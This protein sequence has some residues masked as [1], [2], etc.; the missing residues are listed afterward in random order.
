MKSMVK[1]IELLRIEGILSKWKATTFAGANRTLRDWS[2]TSPTSGYDKVSVKVTWENGVDLSF[3]LDLKHPSTGEEP[4]VEAEIA[5]AIGFGLGRITNPNWTPRQHETVLQRYRDQGVAQLLEQIDATCVIGDFPEAE[6]APSASQNLPYLVRVPSRESKTP[7]DECGLLFMCPETADQATVLE[8]I[9]NAI[10][11][12]DDDNGERSDEVITHLESHGFRFIGN[13]GTV[14]KLPE[15]RGL[16][17]SNSWVSYTTQSVVTV[18]VPAMMPEHA[19]SVNFNA[20]MRVS[21][22]QQAMK[23]WRVADETADDASTPD[24]VDEDAVVCMLAD[25]RHY[26][27]KFGLDFGALDRG[28]HADYLEQLENDRHHASENPQVYENSLATPRNVSPSKKVQ[29][30]LDSKVD[31]SK[32]SLPGDYS[33]LH[34]KLCR[35]LAREYQ[36]QQ[37]PDYGSISWENQVRAQ[38]YFNEY[39]FVKTLNHLTELQGAV[40]SSPIVERVE[41]G[42]EDTAAVQSTTPR[43]GGY[44]AR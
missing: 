39:G 3:R 17:V 36:R 4:D 41:S 37:D 34:E 20:A 33:S 23:A 16:L 28:A 6:Q 10:Y 30:L 40:D 38:D 7:A 32:L 43:R 26:C 35:D 42:K 21:R 15:H 9:D 25:I 24:Q 18:M 13:P 22:L 2:I 44:K 1:S 11:A 5:H 14:E 29:Q 12:A 27:D 19:G 31:L 8:M